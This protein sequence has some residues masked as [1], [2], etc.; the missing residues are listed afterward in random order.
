[1]TGGK[2]YAFNILER[3]CRCP[4]AQVL[5]R[6]LRWVINLYYAV[7][8]G[9]VAKHKSFKAFV[10][11][12]LTFHPQALVAFNADTVEAHER[13]GVGIIA[14]DVYFAFIIEGQLHFT[15]ICVGM[16]WDY[17]LTAIEY[18]HNLVYIIRRKSRFGGKRLSAYCHRVRISPRLVNRHDVKPQVGRHIAMQRARQLL[19]LCSGRAN[20]CDNHCTGYH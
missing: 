15:R 10:C 2:L 14:A 1:M 3:C 7:G 8:Q 16:E 17:G 19:C 4:Q 18:S 13:P 5:R 12:C 11:H 20:R 6:Y 9:R